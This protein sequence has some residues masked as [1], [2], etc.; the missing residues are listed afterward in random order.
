MGNTTESET[1]KVKESIAPKYKGV[2]IYSGPGSEYTYIGS[3]KPGDLFK[4]YSKSGRWLQI[5]QNEWVAA[6]SKNGED[7]CKYKYTNYSS[8]SSSTKNAEPEWKCP[9]CHKYVDEN[10]RID[11]GCRDCYSSVYHKYDPNIN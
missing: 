7:L 4:V 10:Y 1:W 2:A 11:G 6:V 5:E 9:T 3:L 8:D